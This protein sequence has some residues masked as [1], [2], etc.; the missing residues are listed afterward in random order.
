M[1][2]SRK[3]SEMSTKERFNLVLDAQIK[4]GIIELA[5]IERKTVSNCIMDLIKCG[6]KY[7]SRSDNMNISYPE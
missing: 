6:L 2:M 7:R 1:M 3:I 4:K 5:T